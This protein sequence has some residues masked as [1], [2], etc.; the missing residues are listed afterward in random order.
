LSRVSARSG[1]TQD[2][3]RAEQHKL[4]AALASDIPRRANKIVDAN[5]SLDKVISDCLNAISDWQSS[6]SK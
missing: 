3:A 5:Q 6:L 1:G 4:E 2:F